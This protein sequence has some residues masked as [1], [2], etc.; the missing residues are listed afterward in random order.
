[1]FARAILQS[2]SALAP[3]AVGE[4]FRQGAFLT[5]RVVRCPKCILTKDVTFCMQLT[6]GKEVAS[7]VKN[8][9]A[10][11]FYYFLLY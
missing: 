10:S 11:L 7:A 9:T 4:K 3:W 1:M 2:G 6:D 5:S 8:F